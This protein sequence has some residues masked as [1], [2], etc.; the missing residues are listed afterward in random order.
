[1]CEEQSKLHAPMYLFT[2]PQSLV[3]FSRL[4]AYQYRMMQH[5]LQLQ[6]HQRVFGIPPYPT[7]SS[8]WV[9]W[10]HNTQNTVL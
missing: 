8:E 7:T 1:V 4:V 5:P 6:P 2:I 10:N 9:L 3:T